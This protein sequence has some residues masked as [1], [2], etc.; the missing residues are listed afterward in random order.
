[1]EDALAYVGAI[2][3][4]AGFSQAHMVSHELVNEEGKPA[5]LRFALTLEWTGQP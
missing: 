1:M 3:A 5:L 2:A 4:T